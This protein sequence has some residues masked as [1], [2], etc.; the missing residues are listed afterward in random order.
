MQLTDGIPD[1]VLDGRL[2]LRQKTT[3]TID[4][5]D[6]KDFDDALSCEVLPN[7][8]LRLGV[9]IADV[10]HYVREGTA[11]DREAYERGTS[12]YMVNEVIPMLPERLSND[13]CSL[14][15]QEDRLTFSVL[16][17]VHPDGKVEEYRFA[18]SVI[19]STRRFAYEEVQHI[20][21]GKGE[22]AEILALD[23]LA[24]A[25]C[26]RT[27]A[28]TLRVWKRNSR[29]MTGLPDRII[30]RCVWMHKPWR[31]HAAGQQDGGQH[32]AG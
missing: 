6:A 23:R 19:R 16:L 30:K 4:P 1:T 25:V 28:S 32:M 15:P 22:H 2:D 20:L 21:T 14:R 17:D 7:G 31:M 8:L 3:L 10:S 12:V 29:S 26:G 5:E 27:E 11:L 9:H 24:S 13:L 18:R